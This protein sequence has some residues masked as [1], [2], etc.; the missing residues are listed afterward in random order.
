MNIGTYGATKFEVTDGGRRL[1]VFDDLADAELF[2]K[3][4]QG[5]AAAESLTTAAEKASNALSVLIDQGDVSTR[6]A[7]RAALRELDAELRRYR[8][9][10]DARI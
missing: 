10:H 4:R 6:G 8:E 5:L 2:V 7:A 1:A 9:V 3:A